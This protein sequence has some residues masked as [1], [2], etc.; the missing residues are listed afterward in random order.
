MFT[1]RNKFTISHKTQKQMR[2]SEVNR[3]DAESGGKLEPD[4]AAADP[5]GAQDTQQR[6]PIGCV[7]PI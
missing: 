4:A 5:I 3:W 2:K 7:Y 6:A 1:A